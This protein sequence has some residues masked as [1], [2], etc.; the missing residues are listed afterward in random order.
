MP[1]CQPHSNNIKQCALCLL[2]KH[3]MINY[4][5]RNQ[6]SLTE[7]MNC[8]LEAVNV[9]ETRNNTC[10]AILKTYNMKQKITIR[11]DTCPMSQAYNIVI[12]PV[13]TLAFAQFLLYPKV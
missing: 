11:H 13:V 1:N 10:C 7:E 5:S 2:N 6:V 8:L 9:A 12:S 4:D 3:M